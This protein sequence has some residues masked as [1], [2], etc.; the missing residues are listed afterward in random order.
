MFVRPSESLIPKATLQI[1]MK[2]RTVPC[3]YDDIFW[4]IIFISSALGNWMFPFSDVK[5]GE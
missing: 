5:A 1:A 3:M 4:N 2:F